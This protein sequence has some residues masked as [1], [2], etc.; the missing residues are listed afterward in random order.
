MQD[1][2][3]A[4]RYLT[5]VWSNADDPKKTEIMS[6]LKQLPPEVKSHALAWI[7]SY[8][9][10]ISPSR[11]PLVWQDGS[12]DKPVYTRRP[13][14]IPALFPLSWGFDNEVLLSTVY[15]LGW[16]AAEQVTGP[17]GDRLVPSGLDVAAA[18]GSG[19]ADS[20]LASE[21]TKYPV[22]REVMKR[23]KKEYEAK[24]KASP[25]NT[26]LYERWMTALALQWAD[27]V[28]PPD[29]G[30]DEKIWRAKRLQTGLASWATLRHATVLVNERTSAEC[31][32]G[33][34][35]EIVLRAR[36]EALWNRTRVL[37]RL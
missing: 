15:H 28:R 13:S 25:E 20:L 23:L 8:Q 35:E 29:G 27:D 10:F 32:E 31:G 4:F 21:Y 1:Y 30:K 33:G 17:E 16:P 26:N 22:L 36:Q 19:F 6:E 7:G 24:G 11:A 3:K 18:L 12:A 2:F 9:S 37:L 5:T 14:P 34:F